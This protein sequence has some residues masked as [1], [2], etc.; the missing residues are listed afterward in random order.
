MANS[1]GILAGVLDSPR[2]QRQ[3]LIVSI[4][5]F[6]VGLIAFVSIYLLRGTGNAFTDTFSNQPAKLA[7]PQRTVAVTKTQ[8]DLMRT[9]IKTAVARKNLAYAYTIVSPDIRGRMTLADWVKGNIPIVQY[10]AENVDSAAFVPVYHYETSALF[11]VD[12]IPVGHTQTR[13]ELLFSIGLKRAGDKKTGRWLVDYWQP[14]RR[15]PP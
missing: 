3:F 4:A 1:T 8:L 9:F 13:P 6:A 12:L 2:R 5:V 15:P 11:N 10:E 7:K 14:R